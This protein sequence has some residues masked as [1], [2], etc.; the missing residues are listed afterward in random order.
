MTH[1]GGGNRT[2]PWF[3][4]GGRKAFDQRRAMPLFWG[5]GFHLTCEALDAG[6]TNASDAAKEPPK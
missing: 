6:G 1:G 4:G 3:I 2:T 5:E